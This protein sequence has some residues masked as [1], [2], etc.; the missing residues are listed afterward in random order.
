MTSTT[1]RIQSH[2][3][4]DSSGLLGIRANGNTSH[5]GTPASQEQQA[6]LSN[7]MIMLL[8]YQLSISRIF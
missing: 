8:Y 4:V 6:L 2:L 5:V 3:G 1:S 7:I